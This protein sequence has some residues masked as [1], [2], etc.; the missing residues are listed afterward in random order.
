M[1]AVQRH[2]LPVVQPHRR[3]SQGDVVGGMAAVQDF[4]DRHAL[5]FGQPHDGRDAVPNPWRAVARKR[6]ACRPCRPQ[7]VQMHGDQFRHRVRPQECPVHHGPRLLLHATMLIVDENRHQL[8]LAPLRVKRLPRT[9]LRSPRSVLDRQAVFVRLFRRLPPP[10][11]NPREFS[12]ARH[13]SPR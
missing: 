4:V 1:L 12:S 5:Q 8:R 9:L 6:D 11:A 7:A 2:P 3:Q 10:D 13:P